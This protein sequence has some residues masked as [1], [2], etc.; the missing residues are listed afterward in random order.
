[1]ASM[2]FKFKDYRIRRVYRRLEHAVDYLAVEPGSRR[3]VLIRSAESVREDRD[4]I[5]HEF[6]FIKAHGLDCFLRPI[7]YESSE[8]SSIA[9]YHFPPQTT[10]KKL[11]KTRRFSLEEKF[12]LALKIVNI[13]SK[14]NTEHIVLRILNSHNIAVDNETGEIRIIDLTAATTQK[15]NT[16]IS[17]GYRIPES[18]YPYMSPEQTGRIKKTADYRSDFYSLGICLYELFTGDVPFICTNILEYFNSHVARILP[19]VTV[20]NHRIPLKL[21]ELISKLCEKNPE[22]RYVSAWGVRHDIEQISQLYASKTSSDDFELGRQDVR[23]VL[24]TSSK[25]YG[26]HEE[27]DLLDDQLRNFSE[28]QQNLAMIV[29]P[30]GIGK[31]TLIEQFFSGLDEKRFNFVAEGRFY[32]NS[33]RRPFEAL[34]SA[35]SHVVKQLLMTS[36]SELIHWQKKIKAVLGDN[37]HFMTKLI[38]ELEMIIGKQRRPHSLAPREEKNKFEQTFK[39]FLHCFGEEKKPLILFLDDVQW[40]DHAT[41]DLFDYLFKSQYQNYVLPILSYR[42]GLGTSCWRVAELRHKFLQLGF[43]VATL[44]L[45]PLRAKYLQEW[46]IDTFKMT[47]DEA[48]ELARVI[49]SKTGGNPHYVKQFLEKLCET[50]AVY[51]NREN[52]SWCWNRSKVVGQAI[53]E[54]N[55]SVLVDKLRS[56]EPAMLGVL[57]HAACLGEEFSL[58][59]FLIVANGDSSSLKKNLLKLHENGIIIPLQERSLH[60]LK[61]ED[62]FI[63][64]ARFRFVHGQVRLAAE[65]LLSPKKKARIHIAIGEALLKIC[66]PEQ[67]AD[68]IY[69]IC[70]HFN[71]YLEFFSGNIVDVVRI[72]WMAAKK[73]SEFAAERSA[74]NYLVYADQSIRS[75]V[76]QSHYGL[77]IEVYRLLATVGY[78]SK[79][80]DIMHRAIKAVKEHSQADLDLIEVKEVEIYYLLSHDINQ[81]IELG[82]NILRDMGLRMPLKPNRFDV[83]FSSIKAYLALPKN[84]LRLA[85]TDTPSVEDRE[86]EAMFRIGGSV[87]SAVYLSQPMFYPVLINKGMELALKRGHVSSSAVVYAGFATLLSGVFHRYEKAEEIIDFARDLAGRYGHKD[88]IC[89]VEHLTWAFVK[90]WRI[91]VS[92]CLT[93][94]HKAFLTGLHC[95]EYEFAMHA[96]NV[97]CFYSFFCGYTLDSMTDEMMDYRRLVAELDNNHLRPHVDSYLQGIANLKAGSANT[98][99][100]SGQWFDELKMQEVLKQSHDMNFYVHTLKLMLAFFFGDNVAALKNIAICRSK[101][102]VAISSYGVPTFQFYEALVLLRILRSKTSVNLRQKLSYKYRLRCIVKL[103]KKWNKSSP[104]NHYHRLLIIQGLQARLGKEFESSVK[105]LSQGAD[106]ARKNGFVHE[107]AI[108]F[109]AIA[110]TAI[111]SGLVII[112]H[113]Y[114]TRALALYGDWGATKKVQQLQKNHSGWYSPEQNKKGGRSPKSEQLDFDTFKTVISNLAHETQYEDLISLVMSSAANF[115]AAERG[116]VVLREIGSLRFTMKRSFIA[117]EA[118]VIDEV[119]D[120]TSEL[121]VGV[122]NYCLRTKKT[123]VIDDALIPNRTIPGLERDQYIAEVLVRSLVCMPIIL[124]HGT[125]SDLVGAIY[126]ENNLSSHVFSHHKVQMLQLIAQTAAGRIELSKKSQVLETSLKQASEVQQ[127]MLPRAGEISSFS[128]SEFYKSAELTGG[129][130]YGYH[131]DVEAERLYF[132]IGD[133]TGHGVSS[134]LITGTAAGA[135]Y[136]TIETLKRVSK[137]PSLEEEI[138]SISSAVNKAVFSTGAKVNRLMTMCFMVFDIRLGQGVYINAGH[139]CCCVI[140]LQRNSAFITSGGPLG[141]SENPR[142]QIHRFSLRRGESLFFYTDGLL[143]NQGPDGSVFK[144]RRLLKMFKP[145]LVPEELKSAILKE[146]QNIWLA[147]PAADDCAFVILKWEGAESELRNET[148][149][150]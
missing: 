95:G 69:E 18:H 105:L 131:E 21:N 66:S 135:A 138:G 146:A 106:F 149:P 9:T 84:N 128:M 29:G 94:L 126:L 73:A 65:S 30:H 134:S 51:F 91:P 37:A 16:L 22:A 64:N 45:R 108:A 7:E 13:M 120:E 87:G 113:D 46:L 97:H 44:D 41:W 136:A 14:L 92:D 107:A 15:S 34:R 71:P 4:H 142:F 5:K 86:L 112:A 117:G 83:I 116:F 58:D 140:G 80:H 75:E 36:E 144:M 3:Q 17:W 88:Q 85:L 39:Q 93:H 59:E 76:W 53:T 145:G 2:D 111:E 72:N 127:A 121:C 90:P 60:F 10:L 48:F 139:P 103:L 124:G 23:D 62:E 1:M 55:I 110:E 79:D 81:A 32:Q 89:R 57:C 24:S 8:K 125:S 19:S 104:Q 118:L 61:F 28:G 102:D 33:Q 101:Q 132:F 122:L 82:V 12:A 67:L 148:L 40:M 47:G 11:S 74:L 42:D 119:V 77:C 6:D 68:R 25:I 129:D 115:T 20:I 56:F 141:I 54:N 70:E 26:R 114:L 49:V 130:W 35:L 98:T 31:S 123:I 99:V 100:L 63:T 52:W 38:P 137:R 133:V 150:A 96:L 43:E 143:E 50:E 109:E 27:L 147:H 78:L